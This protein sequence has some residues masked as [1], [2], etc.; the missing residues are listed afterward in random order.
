MGCASDDPQVAGSG[1]GGGLALLTLIAIGI[2]FGLGIALPLLRW[3]ALGLFAV[4]A[5]G[6]VLRR[7]GRR[8]YSW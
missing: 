3:I 6:F 7:R 2:L 8:W 5:L 4:W 1:G